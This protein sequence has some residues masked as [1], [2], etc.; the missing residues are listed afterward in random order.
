MQINNDGFLRM[1]HVPED[2]LAVLI[3]GS[4]R[5]DS[6]DIGSGHPDAV[7]P[8]ACGL[9]VCSDAPDVDKRDFEAALEC[10]EFVSAPD[11]Q[12][13]LAFRYRQINQ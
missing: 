1:M 3:E 2:S 9:R 7:I 4:C 10:P 5:D 11:V 6:G 13:Q 8:A 12:R